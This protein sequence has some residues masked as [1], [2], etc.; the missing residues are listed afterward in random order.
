MRER[1]VF[2]DT[3]I[4]EPKTGQVQRLTDVG[5]LPPVTIGLNWRSPFEPSRST[6]PVEWVMRPHTHGF[7]DQ[8]VTPRPEMPN[9]PSLD[10]RAW[11]RDN[12]YNGGRTS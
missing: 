7:I 1:F 11:L 6:Y 3:F 4:A 10:G 8:T 9:S 12:V 5:G 2:D